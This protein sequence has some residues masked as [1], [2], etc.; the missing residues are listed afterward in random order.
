MFV[1]LGTPLQPLSPDKEGEETPV[2]PDDGDNHSNTHSNTH[3]NE[4]CKETTNSEDASSKKNEVTSSAEVVD[5]EQEVSSSSE[6]IGSK[7]EVPSSNESDSKQEIP[8]S[9]ETTSSEQETARETVNTSEISD[10]KQEIA[11]T[12]AS[13]DAGKQGNVSVDIYSE[14]ALDE[15][16]NLDDSNVNDNTFSSPAPKTASAAE[17]IPSTNSS[18]VHKHLAESTPKRHAVSDVTNNSTLSEVSD[19]TI[20][21]GSVTEEKQSN[22]IDEHQQQAVKLRNGTGNRKTDRSSG[23]KRRSFTADT[24]DI[25]NSSIPENSS[26]SASPSTGSDLVKLRKGGTIDISSARPLA[27]KKG[28][29]ET[30]TKTGPSPMK[31]TYRPV[32]MP[33]DMLAN[34]K[35][36]GGSSH[37]DNDSGENNNST[38]IV[39]N[40]NAAFCVFSI[41]QLATLA[42]HYI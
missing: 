41:K 37:D 15:L 24:S 17:N 5:T 4:T 23:Q 25:Q 26:L 2:V 20:N 13:G 28:G 38:R 29:R 19:V 11:E 7:Q 21:E 9:K 8:S 22:K 12:K 18:G 35:E 42:L 31:A 16:E 33:V 32:S 39:N 34:E 10:T 6:T 14:N 36:G 30:K 40:N 27:I 1:F 3:S